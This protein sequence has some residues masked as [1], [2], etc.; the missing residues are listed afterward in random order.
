MRYVGN[1]IRPPSEASSLIL[2]VTTG[3]SH[4]A[5]RFCGAY[6]QQFS[7]KPMSEVVADLDFF[8]S[9]GSELGRRL[10]LADG[11]ALLCKTEDLRTIIR[12][13][14]KRF[15]RLRR[16]ASYANARDVL[17]K[18][19]EELKALAQEGLKLVYIGLESGDDRVL[20]RMNKGNT[21][22]QSI[23]GV[24]RLQEAGIKASVMVLLGLAGAKEEE[25]LDHARLTAEAVAEMQPRYLSCL[26]VMLIPGTPLAEDARQGRFE[27]PGPLAILR[28]LSVLIEKA[29]L[30]R[31]VFRANHASNYLPLSG[32]LK[33]DK[34]RLLRE[35]EDALA[36]E[37]PLMDEFFRAL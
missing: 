33:R 19:D 6:P 24:Q 14:R 22:S 9:Q 3:C 34:G 21:V 37:Q 25:S 29:E 26:T 27:I 18:S 13:A 5:C 20:V 10:F 28:E 2:Q 23:E 15:P 32:V 17:R 30:R 8:S 31:T 4:N 35:I 7:I 1:V 16:I 36:G 11:N 12:E